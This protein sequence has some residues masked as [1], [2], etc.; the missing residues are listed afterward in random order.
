MRTEDVVAAVLPDRVHAR[1]AVEELRERGLGTRR[2][3]E[4]LERGERHLLDVDGDALWARSIIMGM[5]AGVPLGSGIT[6]G[7]VAAGTAVAGGSPGDALIPGV[8]AGSFLGIVLGGAFGIGRSHHSL[9]IVELWSEVE[10]EGNETLLVVRVD[11]DDRDQVRDVL[12]SHPSRE[13]EFHAE[14]A[15]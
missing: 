7:L 1:A 6:Y 15:H 5:I 9:E 4:A 14:L 8:L 10:L 2:L 11:D 3:A 13:P 12:F